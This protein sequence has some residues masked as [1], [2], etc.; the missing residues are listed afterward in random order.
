MTI[1]S[2]PDLVLKRVRERLPEHLK[3]IQL[4]IDVAKHY[5]RPS[6]RLPAGGQNYLFDPG[7]NSAQELND[8]ELFKAIPI[9]FLVFRIY[10]QTHENDPHLNAALNSV[11]GDAM[12]AKTNM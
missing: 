1:F 10:C 2:E 5:H 3:E 4:K 8:D 11:L 12:D 6:G 7:S 9:S